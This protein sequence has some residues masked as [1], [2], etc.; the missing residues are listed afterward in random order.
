MRLSRKTEEKHLSST[1]KPESRND[2]VHCRFSPDM[3]TWFPNQLPAPF[4]ILP[5]VHNRG[6]DHST[7]M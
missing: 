7:N 6:K 3:S 1:W 5:K 2:N 4:N